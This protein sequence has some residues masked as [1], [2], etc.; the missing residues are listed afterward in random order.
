MSDVI[1]QPHRPGKSPAGHEHRSLRRRLISHVPVATQAVDRFMIDPDGFCARQ[2]L[3]ILKDDRTATVGV[4]S[5][6]GRSVVVKR[7]N[8]KGPGHA[9]KRAF[10][11]SRAEHSYRNA[12]RLVEL[13]IRT[14]AP[15]AAVEHRLGPIKRR[16]WYLCEYLPGILLS[17]WFADRSRLDVEDTPIVDQV[18][19]VFGQMKAAAIAHGDTKATNWLVYGGRLYLLDLD[20]MRQ[21]RE[22]DRHIERLRRDRRRFLRN[23]NPDS[24]IHSVFE[25]RLNELLSS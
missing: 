25:Q 7:Y 2:G 15:I 9:L 23:F 14:P 5:F 21:Y 16:S 12:C 6:D 11:V 20:S 8:T 10:R 24:E 1:A 4:T 13:G 17:D 19:T 18:V 22:G 3:N